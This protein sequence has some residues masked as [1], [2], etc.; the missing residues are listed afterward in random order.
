MTH[1]LAI[2]GVE[3]KKNVV[4]EATVGN[5]YSHLPMFDVPTESIDQQLSQL[6]FDQGSVV[7]DVKKAS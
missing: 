7:A 4:D 2:A 3:E 1:D 5:V 6:E